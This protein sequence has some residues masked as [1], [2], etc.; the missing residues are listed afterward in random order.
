MTNEQTV[1]IVTGGAGGIGGGIARR[2]ARAGFAVGIVDRD[3][4]GAEATCA[5]V[6]GLGAESAAA[7]ADITDDTQVRR[8]FAQLRERLGPPA[9]LVNNAGWDAF[10]TFRESTPELWERVIAINFRGT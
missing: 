8:A 1:A 7:E 10:T 4:A 3:L 9:V 2:L 5:A 6:R